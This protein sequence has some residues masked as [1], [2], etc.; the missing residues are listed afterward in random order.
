V[1][2]NKHIVFSDMNGLLWAGLQA[3][4]ATVPQQQFCGASF[5]SYLFGR[6]RTWSPRF[7]LEYVIFG[8]QV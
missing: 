6:G 7:K 1:A 8:E 4:A 3:V 2:F 5:T